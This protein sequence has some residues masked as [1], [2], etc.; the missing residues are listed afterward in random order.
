[1]LCEIKAED[2]CGVPGAALEPI[3][4]SSQETTVKF[5]VTLEAG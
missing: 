1:M 2:I 3:C 4:T 5:S